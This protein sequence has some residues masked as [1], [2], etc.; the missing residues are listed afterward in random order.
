MEQECPVEGK[1]IIKEPQTAPRGA[2]FDLDNDQTGQH[3]STDCSVEGVTVAPSN[4]G[5]KVPN[6]GARSFFHLM[7][8]NRSC[9]IESKDIK[10]RVDRSVMG[11]EKDKDLFILYPWEARLVALILTLVKSRSEP[12]TPALF[13]QLDSLRHNSG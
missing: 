3:T 2:W 8:S 4:P 5:D 11:G 13:G 1:I 10:E 6:N 9:L 7:N 12:L